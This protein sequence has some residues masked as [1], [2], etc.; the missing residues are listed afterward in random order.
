[1]KSAI[2]TLKFKYLD[3]GYRESIVLLPGWATDCRIFKFLDLKFNYILPGEDFPC[4][5]EESLCDFIKKHNLSKISMLGWSLGGLAAAE[6]ATKHPYFVDELILVSVR[7]EYK[8][9]SLIEIKNNLKKSKEGFL[10]KFYKQCFYKKENM[11]KYKEIFKVLRSGF[12]LSYLLDTLDYLSKAKIPFKSLKEIS[13]IKIIHGRCDEIAPIAEARNISE[14]LKGA[15]FIE[16]DE[17][18]H[19]PFLEANLAECL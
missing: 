8:K 16:M 5:F 13:K 10:Y 2:H 12:E 11:A 19:I 14:K 4:F 15:E 6:F 7:E 9:E 3:R 18:G 1:M 17:C